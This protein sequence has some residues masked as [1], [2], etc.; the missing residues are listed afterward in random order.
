M[1]TSAQAYPQSRIRSS[2]DTRRSTTEDPHA[3]CPSMRGHVY[4]I[5][6]T[7]TH[8]FTIGFTRGDPQRRCAALQQVTPVMLTVI[9]SRPG[10][11]Q[12]EQG[13]H[14]CLRTYRVAGEEWVELPED[15]VWGVCRWF[16]LIMP[17]TPET[18]TAIEIPYGHR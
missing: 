18:K 15:V 5:W 13:I 16:G 10:T 12:L 7:G 1:A 9:A 11:V 3:W 14:H 8:R 2:D 6:A 4:L 17:D